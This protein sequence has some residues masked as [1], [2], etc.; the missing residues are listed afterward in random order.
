MHRKPY[1]GLK[2]INSMLTLEE[3]LRALYLH[4]P[5]MA[6]FIEDMVDNKIFKYDMAK[7]ARQL[8]T[9]I[10]NADRELNSSLSFETDEEYESEKDNRSNNQSY[11]QIHYRNYI[12]DVLGDSGHRAETVEKVEIEDRTVDIPT[13]ET[14]V[15]AP[16]RKPGRPAKPKAT[17]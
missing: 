2:T 14:P 13:G 10:R 15:E 5:V 1:G 17:D 16:K 3:K 6:D 12:K 7:T 9:K 4:L 11:G 8:I